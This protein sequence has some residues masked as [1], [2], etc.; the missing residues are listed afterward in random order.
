MTFSYGTAF[1]V[2]SRILITCTHNLFSKFRNT[3]AHEVEF[4]P[5]VKE[6]EIKEYYKNVR[7][8]LHF[9]GKLMTESYKVKY[10]YSLFDVEKEPLL[11][12]RVSF[13]NNPQNYEV[14]LVVL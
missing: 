4:V 3:W 8:S 13:E 5:G 10:I 14:S 2:S 7:R 11:K 9:E 12:E 6:G 1:Q